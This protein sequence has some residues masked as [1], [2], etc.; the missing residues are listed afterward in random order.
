MSPPLLRGRTLPVAWR[1][2]IIGA[3][4]SL[5]TTIAVDSLPDSKATIAGGIMII[6]AFIGGT[7]AALRS[8]DPGAAG[9][10]SG[11]LAGGVAVLTLI[12]TVVSTVLSGATVARP[13]L[14]RVVFIVVAGGL[15][16]CIAPI[17]G[18]VS[19][20]VGGWVANTVF[21]RLVTDANTP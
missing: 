13:S 2:A 1:F 11:V 17:F 20:R 9:F 4:A 6:G 18:L 21:S 10:R 15:V 12:V 19:G 16:L 3:L 14:A 5:P 7:I 8:A